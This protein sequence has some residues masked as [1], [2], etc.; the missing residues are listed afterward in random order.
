MGRVTPCETAGY[1]ARSIPETPLP[2]LVGHIDVAEHSCLSGWVAD[3][4]APDQPVMLEILVD[5]ASDGTVLAADLRPDLAQLGKYGDGRHGFTHFFARPLA[6]TRA[7]HIVVHTQQ[8][9]LRPPGGEFV[10]QAHA[11]RAP[12]TL[13]PLL[14]TSAG[15]SGSTLL[16]ARLA[17]HPAITL[18]H[19]PPFEMKLATYYAK[20]FEVLT[21]PGDPLRSVPADKIY[22]DPYHLGLNPFHH[23]DF[24]ELLG[25]RAAFFGFWRDTAAPVVAGAFKET[26]VRFYTRLAAVQGK[27]AVAWFAEKTSIFDP[28]RGFVR[29]VFPEVREVVL[30]RDP[31]D[32]FCSYRAFWSAT[33]EY[34]MQVMRTMRDN[35]LRIHA[36]AAADTLILRYEDLVS[37]GAASMA[38]VG[39]FMGRAQPI[40]LRTAAEAAL[41]SGHGTA[42]SPERSLGRWRRELRSEEILAIDAEFGEML[43]AFDY[44]R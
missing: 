35:L 11:L 31:R 32:V 5:G 40:P 44:E 4:S 14:V 39:A 20:A 7:Y 27:P 21:A 37:A 33:P 13:A 8:A 6:I 17:N 16:M 23:H 25:S 26:I 9:D 24:E 42:G 34:G 28:V 2:M 3:P 12:E 15:R 22:D 43:E 10:L 30:V 38:R 36:E 19:Q 41:F 18:A 29:A 1:P